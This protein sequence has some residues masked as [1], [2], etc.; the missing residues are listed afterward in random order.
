MKIRSK[1]E[2]V[3]GYIIEDLIDH[4]NDYESGTIN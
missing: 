1:I 2:K 4:M 3:N